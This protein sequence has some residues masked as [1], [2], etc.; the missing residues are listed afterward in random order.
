MTHSIILL[1]IVTFLFSCGEN[2]KS[3]G[4]SFIEKSYGDPI[5]LNYSQ[6]DCDRSVTPSSPAQADFYIDGEYKSIDSQKLDSSMFYK[7][8][9][10][11]EF[12]LIRARN[13]LLNY[14]KGQGFEDCAQIREYETGTFES[15]ARSITTILSLFEQEFSQKLSDLKLKSLKL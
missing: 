5:L 13:T 9:M 10:G 3:R 7:V 12:T 14:K 1:F 6:E 8:E 15:A 2:Q 4:N 11:T